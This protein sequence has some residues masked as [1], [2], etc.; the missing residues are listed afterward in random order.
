MRQSTR[1]AKKTLQINLLLICVSVFFFA[2]TT[3][4][5][6]TTDSQI[7]QLNSTL[8]TLFKQKE[9]ISWGIYVYSLDKNEKLYALHSNKLFDPASTIKIA[10]LAV[11]AEKLGWD[12][13]YETTLSGQKSTERKILVGDL[14]V[15]GTGDPTI[16]KSE[17]SID[18]TFSKWTRELSNKGIKQIDGNI[19]GD[20]RLF[21]DDIWSGWGPGWAWDDFGFGFAS[22]T[23]ALQYNENVT[24]LIITPST[25][26]GE[27]AILQLDPLSGLTLINQLETVDKDRDESFT[28]RRLPGPSNLV[29]RGSIPL[30][31]PAV[32]R[33]IAIE[34]STRFFV[35]SLRSS[36]INNGINVIGK[37]LEIENLSGSQ[38]AK[39]QP[40][41]E[42]LLRH[43]SKELSNIAVKMMKDSSNLYAE[44][45]M[46]TIGYSSSSKKVSSGVD[47]IT[48]TLISWGVN[49]NDF[50]IADGSGL[51][52]LN[53][54]S[55]EMLVAILKH[56]HNDVSHRNYFT[57]LLP[58]A[59]IDGTLRNRLRKSSATNNAIAKTGTKS[60]VSALVGYVD[61]QEGERLAFAI[62]ANNF[63]AT[64]SAINEIIDSAV[65]Q[66]S[67]FSRK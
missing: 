34:N 18:D 14:V 40:S 49:K 10:T 16:G 60:N 21:S 53:L 12:F 51:S 7:E 47:I 56:M 22:P 24:P 39:H 63:T 23:G 20:D 59:G 1:S 11:A 19:V 48:E 8:D 43:Y 44:S 45:L 3:R 30:G 29:V 62:L 17:N 4:S 33:K 54:A 26:I 36:L 9:T 35:T 41:T 15:K 50:L 37:A 66:L 6:V 42:I 67:D 2:E 52:P 38:L 46:R 55:A 58:V 13:R 27:L 32:I 25:S 28:L 61:T 65:V 57:P 64:N 31:S 5:Q